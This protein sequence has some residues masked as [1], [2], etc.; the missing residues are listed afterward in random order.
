LAGCRR[1]EKKRLRELLFLQ[2]EFVI[3]MDRGEDEQRRG[4]E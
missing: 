1:F 2:P 4:R 3:Q